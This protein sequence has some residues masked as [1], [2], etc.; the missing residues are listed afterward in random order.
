[1]NAQTKLTAAEI[2][3]DLAQCIGGDGWTRH[4]INRA[5]LM[6][7][8]I[9]TMRELCQAYWLC[10]VIASHA[11]Q[12]LGV[13]ANDDRLEYFQLWTVRRQG[14]GCIVEC[15]ADTGESPVVCQRIGF[16]DFPLPE[17]TLYCNR[18]DETHFGLMLPSEY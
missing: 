14:E 6:T 1:M 11:P 8:G 13:K 5:L 12:R 18:L 17:L 7:D 9:L 10:D 3:A 4:G 16:S 2:Q 15:R